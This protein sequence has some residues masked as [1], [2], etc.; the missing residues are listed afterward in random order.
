MEAEHIG[1]GEKD[2]EQERGGGAG[3]GRKTD[4]NGY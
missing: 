4:Q 2:K 3:G 1:K